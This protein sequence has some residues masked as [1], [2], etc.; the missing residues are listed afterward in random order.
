M[1]RSFIR[2]ILEHTNNETISF[3]GGLPDASLFP[4]EA[5]RRSANKVLSQPNVLQYG[6]STGYGPL[7]EKIA[8]MYTEDGF[9]TSSEN[10]LITS[11]SQQALDIISRYHHHKNITI[12]SPSYLGAMNVF[13][14][15]HLKQEGVELK[16]SGIDVDAFKSSFTETKLA[17][18]IP[19]FQNP[20]G[21]TYSSKKRDKLARL[22]K[23]YDGLLIEDSPYSKLYFKRAYKSI[24]SLVPRQSYSLGS[25]SKT[26]APALR[27][28]WIRA[29]AKLLEPLI[30][31]KEAMDLHTNGLVQYILN[32]YL[33]DMSSYED[34][35]ALLR[36]EYHRKMLFFSKML[37]QILPSFIYIKPKGGM[38]IYGKFINV[39]TSSLVEKCLEKGVV[40]VPGIEFYLD[41]K[42]KN[43][44]RFNFTNARQ[45]DIMDGLQII[46][47]V[48][49]E[50]FY[51]EVC[52]KAGA[53]FVPVD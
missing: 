28:G 49:E 34:H 30:G 16:K 27:I 1:K 26:L 44:I 37:D 7:K 29:D 9:E 36:K 14:L 39:D 10:I 8:Q 21:R 41:D 32:D 51:F 22:I 33:E 35:L 13:T 5:L 20:T 19:D 46:K 48:I 43:E 25:F 42:N 53:V 31:Y 3:A 15:N 18:L 11:G 6:T 47:D 45:K 23:E 17:Y 2:E 40:F 12:E 38:F 50:E 24:S 52:G 4:N